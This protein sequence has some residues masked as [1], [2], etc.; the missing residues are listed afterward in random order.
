MSA[1]RG[2]HSQDLRAS[3]FSF[4][5]SGGAGQTRKGRGGGR[6]G[7]PGVQQSF[8]RAAARSPGRLCALGCRRGRE[9]G[10][11]LGGL[12]APV[13]SPESACVLRAFQPARLGGPGRGRAASGLPGR[14]WPPLA[15]VGARL[16]HPPPP[17]PPAPRHPHPQP[18]PAR[19]GLFPPSLRALAGSRPLLKQAWGAGA[20][21]FRCRRR[22]PC[23]DRV[24]PAA[25]GPEPVAS[26]PA[27]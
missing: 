5:A 18:R 6:L 22:T 12:R 23:G 3:A 21:V 16:G 7:G 27:C 10:R 9:R 4:P 2:P 17:G 24:I 13:V 25:R 19:A 11:E 26:P 15:E 8:G 20:V 14:P 1:R